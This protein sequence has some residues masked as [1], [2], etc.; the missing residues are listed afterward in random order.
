MHFEFTA[1][2]HQYRVWADGSAARI[3][4]GG[5]FA[6]ATVLALT[7]TQ[8]RI[9]AELVRATS[10][11]GWETLAE[12]CVRSKEDDI[13]DPFLL[14]Q[15]HIKD[16]RKAL[17]CPGLVRSAGE[18][19]FLNADVRQIRAIGGAND[20]ASFDAPLDG[21]DGQIVMPTLLAADWMTPNARSAGASTDLREVVFTR[22]NGRMGVF[23][24]AAGSFN[25][26]TAR[27]FLLTTEI[28]QSDLLDWANVDNPDD[29][30]F[31]AFERTGELMVVDTRAGERLK[32]VVG[33]SGAEASL[34]WVDNDAAGPGSEAGARS[35]PIHFKCGESAYST[36]DGRL[37][38]K[39]LPLGVRHTLKLAP[40]PARMLM[41]F[42]NRGAIGPLSHAEIW[43]AVWPERSAAELSPKLIRQTI[44]RVRREFEPG[45]IILA[46]GSEGQYALNARVSL[47]TNGHRNGRMPDG[48]DRIPMRLVLPTRFCW[49][50]AVRGGTLKLREIMA[51]RPDGECPVL[52]FAADTSL[53]TLKSLLDPRTHAGR[54]FLDWAGVDPDNAPEFDS[55]DGS[56]WRVG[57]ADNHIGVFPNHTVEFKW[58]AA[59]VARSG[60][61]LETVM[62][63]NLG[64][65]GPEAELSPA[66]ER[67]MD[68]LAKEILGAAEQ[69]K[70]KKLRQIR[71]PPVLARLFG[72][73]AGSD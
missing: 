36:T 13:K 22:A 34:T 37:V 17:Q 40:I 68:Q 33:P 72:R 45:S 47:W 10:H 53:E 70:K 55:P 3:E 24:Y 20:S 25:P 19:Y 30:E 66:E 56:I 15:Q 54:F 73:A 41:L 2:M 69:P 61:A 60:S 4:E 48:L 31:H 63:H 58:T 52:G 7:P 11:I 71:V 12:R 6:K 64:F 42:L 49:Y 14:V 67:A 18:A 27:H 57:N 26:E 29:L 65:A 23:G 62:Q 44:R 43:E 39:H 1:G 51:S 16:L 32:M 9:M 46:L 59:R 21:A 5:D 38:E 50:G 35:L 28:P 8:R